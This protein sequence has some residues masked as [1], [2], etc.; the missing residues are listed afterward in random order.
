[1]FGATCNR[2]GAF[3]MGMGGGMGWLGG[4]LGLLF[5]AGLALVLVVLFVWLWKRGQGHSEGSS[6]GGG[7]SSKNKALEILTERYARGEISREEYLA[8]RNDLA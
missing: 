7:M 5:L 3:G 8:M 6:L 4:L 2:M 1:M